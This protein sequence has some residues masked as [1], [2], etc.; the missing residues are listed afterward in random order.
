MILNCQE[1]MNW[2]EEDTYNNLM[3]LVADYKTKF[4]T[5]IKLITGRRDM[6]YNDVIIEFNDKT[7]LELSVHEHMLGGVD[8]MIKVDYK[9]DKKDFIC[10]AELIDSYVNKGE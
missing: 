2:K 7:K 4:N 5:R 10:L 1:Y 8:Y 3:D 6:G 9:G